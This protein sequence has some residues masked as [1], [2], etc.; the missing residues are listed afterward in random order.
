MQFPTFDTDHSEANRGAATF[1]YHKHFAM[2]S[3][4]LSLDFPFYI[5]QLQ[6]DVVES[7]RIFHE[8]PSHV[9]AIQV[10]RGLG[11]GKYEEVFVRTGFGAGGTHSPCYLLLDD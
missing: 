10:D 1:S 6:R 11:Q 8:H 4:V 9:P 7:I 2:P 5:F 3:P